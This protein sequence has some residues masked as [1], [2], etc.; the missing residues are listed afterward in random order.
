MLL[1]CVLCF[2][3][4]FGLN[5]YRTSIYQ[6]FALA[7][8]IG[9]LSFLFNLV[10]FKSKIKIKRILPDL[11][12]VDQTVTYEIE[13]TNLSNKTEKGLILYEKTKDPRPDFHTLLTQTEPYENKRNAWDKMTLYYRWTWQLKKKAK[14]KLP[15]LPLPDLPPAEPVRVRV[16]FM[17]RHRGYIYFNGIYLGR[18]DILGLFSRLN[19]KTKAQKLLILPK[20]YEITP[21]NLFSTRRHDP[22]GIS[23]A[24]S[25]GNAY[26][27]M[28]LRQYRPGD[29]MKNIHWRT[30]AK[31]QE[32]VVKEFEDEFFVRHALILDTHLQCENEWLFEK[33]IS[34]ASSFIVTLQ[35]HESILDLILVGNQVYTFSSGRG[36]SHTRQMLEIMASIEPEKKQTISEI[37]PLLKQKM[38][39]FSGSICIF[40]SWSSTHKEIMDLFFIARIPV[41]IMII[42]DEKDKIFRKV[43]PLQ[44]NIV[45]FKVVD[46]NHVQ[47]ELK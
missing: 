34:I 46:V 19:Y 32:L 21:P 15:A 24:S 31:T 30:F 44:N 4:V 37:Q 28:S 3:S 17:P 1:I 7:L 20:R 12:T 33:A 41:L 45:Q 35:S 43:E 25:I 47:D 39:Q 22:G 2:S 23:L 13:I 9:C 18:P 40:L 38:N 11:A 5:I 36:L 10:P 6:I 27:F 42:T 8:S 26:E 29:S 16:N 14:G